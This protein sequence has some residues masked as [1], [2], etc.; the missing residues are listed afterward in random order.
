MTTSEAATARQAFDALESAAR[1]EPYPSLEPR[2]AW[3]ASLREGIKSARSDLVAAIDADFSGRAEAETLLAEV[4]PTLAGARYAMARLPRW[5]RPERRGVAWT[6]ELASNR[7]FYQ[8][9]GVV[10]VV[11]PWNYPFVLA[12][13]PTINAL[14]AGNRVVLRPSSQTPRTSELIAR[15]VEGALPPDVARVLAGSRAVADAMLELPFDHLVFTGS[16]SVGK[17]VMR[18]AADHLTPVTLE[19]GGKSPV[20]LHPDFPLETA[21]ERIVFGKFFNA[22]QTCLAPDYVFV[23][24]DRR[25]ALLEALERA[26]DAAYPN[27]AANPDL[28]SVQSPERAERLEAML[29]D[30]RAKGARIAQP[31]ARDADAA[32]T[33]FPPTFVLDVTDDMRIAQEEIFGPILP[34]RAF[35]D[36]DEAFARIAAGPRPLAAYYFDRD[37]RRIDRF[38]RETV[39]GGAV[40]NDTLLHF[41]QDDLPFGGVGPSGMGRYHAFEGFKTFSNARSVHAPW[42]YSLSRLL[43]AP[44]TKG[45]RRVIDATLSRS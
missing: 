40:I 29:K 32:P 45:R 41:A 15:V 38:L 31:Q 16:T 1:K 5:M 13:S 27:A 14:A 6:F 2:R 23:R 8:P 9:L 11:A 3:L 10:G 42:R 4:F 22:G 7:V 19:L 26:L 39:S 25:D 30:A 35:D 36:L 18:A 17:R 20:V 43:R 37:Q 24:R 34:I 21:A 33:R 44:W 12:L 28:T